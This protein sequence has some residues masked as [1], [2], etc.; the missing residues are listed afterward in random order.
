M[1]CKG[2]RA[3]YLMALGKAAHYA[4]HTC[5]QG[6]WEKTWVP[7]IVLNFFF[8]KDALCDEGNKVAVVWWIDKVKCQCLKGEIKRNK[9]MQSQRK[10]WK[11]GNKGEKNRSF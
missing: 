8:P 9:E 10:V 5:Y 1:V 3:T 6:F 2:D 11:E 4:G 7:L